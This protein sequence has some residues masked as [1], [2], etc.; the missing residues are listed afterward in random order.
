MRL[1]EQPMI[2]EVLMGVLIIG[3]LVLLSVVGAVQMFLK[4]RIRDEEAEP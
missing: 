1:E 4:S 2:M 3:L